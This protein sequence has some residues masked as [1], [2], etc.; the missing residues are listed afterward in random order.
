MKKFLYLMFFFGLVAS[1]VFVG[2][3]DKKAATAS[4]DAAQTATG[5]IMIYTSIY[6]DVIE[7]MDRVL[8]KQFP[9]CKIEFFYGGTGLLPGIEGKRTAPS[10]HCQRS[11]QY[12]FRL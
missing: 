1:F 3:K 8:A 4:P 11:C 6:E 5:K 9:N 2:C 10:L 12:F 7:A